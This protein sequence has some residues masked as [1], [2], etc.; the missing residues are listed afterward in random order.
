[1]TFELF[2]II[3][4]VGLPAYLFCNYKFASQLT[5]AYLYRKLAGQ[6]ILIVLTLAEYFYFNSLVMGMIFAAFVVWELLQ[7]IGILSIIGF[8]TFTSKV[9]K[10]D[11]AIYALLFTN[12]K[13]RSLFKSENSNIYFFK[14]NGVNI[15]FDSASDDFQ[16]LSD[17]SL[18]RFKENIKE[19]KSKN[20]SFE[21]FLVLNCDDHYLSVSSSDLKL[22]DVDIFQ[23]DRKHFDVLRMFKI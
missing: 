5:N 10:K 21:N 15:Y 9:D 7:V 6:C 13:M 18:G 17:H 22:I 14:N 16:A 20:I 8:L 19:E 11:S 1:M 2:L 12:L 23:M 4:V 3:L